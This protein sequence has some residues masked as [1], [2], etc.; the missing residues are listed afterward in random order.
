MEKRGG[1]L[2][3]YFCAGSTLADDTSRI[4]LTLQRR[5]KE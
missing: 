3:L 1:L 4:I 2:S 5:G